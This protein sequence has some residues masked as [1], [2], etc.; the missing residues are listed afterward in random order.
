[1]F[2]HNVWLRITDFLLYVSRVKVNFVFKVDFIRELDVKIFL[3]ANPIPLWLS[4]AIFMNVH[5]YR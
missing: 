3:A 1:M 4:K 2:K 5:D